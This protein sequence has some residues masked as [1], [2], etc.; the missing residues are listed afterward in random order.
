MFYF[1]TKAV[2]KNLFLKSTVSLKYPQIN[3]LQNNLLSSIQYSDG[4]SIVT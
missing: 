4:S 1:Y 2:I 3:T